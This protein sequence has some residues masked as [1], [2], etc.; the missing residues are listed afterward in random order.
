MSEQLPLDIIGAR[1]PPPRQEPSF[2][3]RSH[4]TVAEAQA[5]E[6]QAQ[7]QETAIL[8]WFRFQDRAVSGVKLTPSQV[9]RNF[10]GWELTSI[11]RAL[12][13]LTTKGHLAHWPGVRIDGP[14]GAKEST[15]SLSLFDDGGRP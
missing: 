3:V 7:T 12:T 1:Q 6:A 13:N 5:G 9:H 4:V 14:R 15:W 2:H 8:E 11:R 10:D